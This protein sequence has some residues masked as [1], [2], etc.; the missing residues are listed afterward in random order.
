M[1]IRREPVVRAQVS[2]VHTCTLGAGVGASLPFLALSQELGCQV[3]FS[4]REE[5]R[6]GMG[7]PRARVHS[8]AGPRG[9]CQLEI[10]GL[11]GRS[12]KVKQ[13]SGE[14]VGLG[15][16]V[17]WQP[18]HLAPLW[19]AFQA[20]APCVLEPRA[21]KREDRLG[22]GGRAAGRCAQTPASGRGPG[23]AQLLSYT[24]CQ[25]WRPVSVLE[26]LGFSHVRG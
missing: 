20:S 6:K 19:A 12:E 24:H 8:G 21:G 22:A 3:G 5:Q 25:C 18:A 15:G 26:G 11:M 10:R 9:A 2:S 4:H 7:L 13:T 23:G 1:C 14:P 16:A 17:T